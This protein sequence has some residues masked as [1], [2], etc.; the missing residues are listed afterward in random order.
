M[1]WGLAIVDAPSRSHREH[2][3]CFGLA[4]HGQDQPP[5]A[6]AGAMGQ[7]KPTI[8]R[9]TASGPRLAKPP[10]GAILLP[11]MIRS[12]R[13]LVALFLAAACPAAA[14]APAVDQGRLRL[15]Y[16]IEFTGLTIATL[17]IDVG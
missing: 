15:D 8:G 10:D 13:W 7:P 4:V 3:R 6:H 2:M 14:Q 9:T 12:T 17:D 16:D 11:T 1:I 5:I